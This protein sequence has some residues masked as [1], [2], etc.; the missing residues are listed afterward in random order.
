MRFP[1]CLR[2]ERDAALEALIASLEISTLLI[3]PTNALAGQ[4]QEERQITTNALR[5]GREMIR[6]VQDGL[7]EDTS[8]LLRD[9]AREL[10]DVI[11]VRE[12]HGL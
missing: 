8:L 5:I 6:L 2:S 7:D 3:G 4:L 10:S 12:E 11:A 1:F 9:W